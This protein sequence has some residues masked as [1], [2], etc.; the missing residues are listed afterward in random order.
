MA[1]EL[2]SRGEVDVKLTWDLSLIY[3]TVEEMWKDLDELKIVRHE[4]HMPV[5]TVT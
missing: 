2:K 1:E 3:K 5:V 4:K